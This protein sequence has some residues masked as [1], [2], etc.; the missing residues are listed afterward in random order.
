M[1][2]L[3]IF[4]AT[5][6]VLSLLVAALPV[7]AL[8]LPSG[9]LAYWKLDEAGVA[10]TAADVT[11]NYPG[12]L[13]GNPMW[14][15][16]HSGN[17][18]SFGDDDDYVDIGTNGVF[19]FMDSTGDFT[20]DAWIYPETMPTFASGI[21]A[22]A[23][24][25]NNWSGWS[26]YFYS[27]GTLGFSSQHEWQVISDPGMITTYDWFHVAITK[28]GTTYRLYKDG[29]LVRMGDF[30]YFE[31]SPTTLKIGRVYSDSTDPLSFVG[32]IDEVRI[33]NRALT[34]QEI[35]DTTPPAVLNPVVSP[36]PAAFGTPV[37]LECTV[38]DVNGVSL[39]QYKIDDNTPV[40]MSPADGAFNGANEIARMYVSP[41]PGVYSIYFRGMDVAGNWSEWDSHVYLAV[42][43]PNGG[44][45]TGGGWI[46]TPEGSFGADHYR[47]GKATFG[48]V[49]KY[50]HGKTTPT[51]CTEFQFQA[52]DL[53]F[54]STTYSWLV[55][56]GAKAR[57]AG[58]G[59]VNGES[60]YYFWLT[61]I[62]GQLPGGG[63]TDKLRMRIIDGRT[64][65]T[66]YDNDWGVLITE[67]PTTA[68]GGGSI[69]IHK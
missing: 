49:S 33:W 32:I 5:F 41:S 55:I 11:G 12:M 66:V 45:V 50:Q 69:V 59:T 61:A 30:P 68:L 6:I 20:I 35:F 37:L 44:F 28:L 15:P 29:N 64:G 10:T 27:D 67:D 23:A 7:N 51:G 25:Q 24:E 62:D 21:V 58:E 54:K 53:N 26:F 65:D 31:P 39:A 60:G 9:L 47:V 8:Q 18:L 14:V 3:G 22:K 48:F 19:N 13:N 36:N 40:D 1:R 34:I 17:A 16:G 52:G 43:D 57:Y 63:G 4:A 38:N 56:S 46:M 42:Y 2:K